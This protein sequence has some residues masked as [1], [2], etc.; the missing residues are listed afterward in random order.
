MCLLHGNDFHL[1]A[2]HINLAGRKDGGSVTGILDSPH[3]E[4][5][6]VGLIHSQLINVGHELESNREPGALGILHLT[7]ATQQAML[8]SAAVLSETKWLLEIPLMY[9]QIAKGN[10]L[11]PMMG[12][13]EVVAGDPFAWQ[14]VRY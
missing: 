7:T 1:P 13:N 6:S 14:Q 10:P 3:A 2:F 8:V 9:T 12:Q 5:L 11:Q 4:S